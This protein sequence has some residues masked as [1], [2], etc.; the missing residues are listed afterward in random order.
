MNAESIARP[1]GMV[2]KVFAVICMAIFWLLPF[3]P[4]VAIAAV[5]TTCDTAGWPRALAKTGAMLCTLWT[6]IAAGMLLLFVCLRML[7]GSWS[8]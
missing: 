3:S 1:A 8:F 7:Q 2:G 6:V 5:A 4:F